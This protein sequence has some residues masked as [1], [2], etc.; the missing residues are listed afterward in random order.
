M[1]VQRMCADQLRYC[2]DY[3]QEIVAAE[4]CVSSR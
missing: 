2:A 3:D 1:G 4:C